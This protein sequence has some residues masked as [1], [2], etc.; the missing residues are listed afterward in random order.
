MLP[1]SAKGEALLLIIATLDIAGDP[2]GLEFGF[3]K[4]IS[5]L[6]VLLPFLLPFTTFLIDSLLALEVRPIGND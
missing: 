1:K 3:Q 4:E 2:E 6:P 5:V